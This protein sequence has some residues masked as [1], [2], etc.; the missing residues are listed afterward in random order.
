MICLYLEKNP[1]VKAKLIQEID[2]VIPNETDISSDNL[3]KLHYTQAV[4]NET[5]RM[6]GPG[7]AIFSRHVVK[8]NAS[9]EVQV[10]TG[11]LV[12]LS[13]IPNNYNPT[14]YVNPHEFNPDRWL[15]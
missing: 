4:I 8:D 14:F 11:T 15:N 12:N 3:K 10:K 6:Y 9:K 13:F 2:E 1:A 7:T 5:G